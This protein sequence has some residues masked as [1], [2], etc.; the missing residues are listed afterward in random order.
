[1]E[2][3]ENMECL[4]LGFYCPRCHCCHCRPL[5]YSIA[6][7]IAISTHAKYFKIQIIQITM[8]P[9]YNKIGR[10]ESTMSYSLEQREEGGL[11]AHIWQ[12]SS[13]TKRIHLQFWARWRAA[14]SRI[15]GSNLIV[16]IFPAVVWVWTGLSWAGRQDEGAYR[17][18]N[19]NYR[20]VFY[21]QIDIQHGLSYCAQPWGLHMVT[22]YT[23]SKLGADHPDSCA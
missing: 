11:D 5:F 16:G 3:E 9:T 12:W 23:R 1:M 6:I 14:A 17:A 22:Q 15:C 8:T 20:G 10:V 21:V 7:A 18:W 13:N 4:F 19:F 2:E